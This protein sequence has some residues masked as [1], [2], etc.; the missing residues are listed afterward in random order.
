MQIRLEGARR[1]IRS[2]PIEIGAW[3]HYY[4]QRAEESDIQPSEHSVETSTASCGI[5][6]APSS[7]IQLASRW[8][9]QCVTTHQNCKPAVNSSSA[10]PRR[11]L[12]VGDAD[13]SH[14]LKVVPVDD[15]FSGIRYVALSYCWGNSPGYKLTLST[16]ETLQSG[17]GIQEFPKTTD[18]MI[19]LSGIIR[20]IERSTGW[21]NIA[22]LWEPFIIEDL[23]WKTTFDS[24]GAGA[25]TG[26][27]WSWVVV[28]Q[29]RFS[30]S[31]AG[32][33][34]LAYVEEMEDTAF[35]NDSS[36]RSQAI[37]RISCTPIK[38]QRSQRNP[39]R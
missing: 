37:I 30:R 22:G 8:L 2:D 7:I 3:P 5:S 24:R 25:A 11:L 18:R 35:R 39:T 29:G 13:R 28:D 10:L 36:T 21:R 23:L 34:F 4:S 15:S 19:A 32:L 6:T 27:S 14:R 31:R 33:N 1:G 17:I 20:L 16:V 38:V 12:N 9:E 26:P